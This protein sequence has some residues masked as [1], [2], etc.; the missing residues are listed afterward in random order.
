[1]IVLLQFLEQVLYQA[2][3]TAIKSVFE[4]SKMT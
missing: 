2:E 1:M 4:C 3:K